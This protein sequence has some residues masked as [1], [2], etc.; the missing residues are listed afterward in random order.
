MPGTSRQVV[1]ILFPGDVLCSG[2]V[3]READGT[4]TPAN[5]GELW[6]LRWPVFAEL[7]AKDAAVASFYH[8]AIDRQM[9]CRAIHVAAI[10]QFD[11]PVH[12]FA[13]ARNQIQVP[14]GDWVK[15]TGIDGDSP[16]WRRVQALSSMRRVKDSF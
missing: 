14:I 6:R 12:Q 9:A 15:G 7:S 8:E 1:A 2:F 16:G 10:G 11:Q 4:L 5:T 13:A 3:P